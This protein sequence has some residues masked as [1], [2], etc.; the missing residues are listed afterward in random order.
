LALVKNGQQQGIFTF[1]RCVIHVPPA[2]CNIRYFTRCC[3]TLTAFILNTRGWVGGPLENTRCYD[4]LFPFKTLFFV[5]FLF[6]MFLISAS[7]E[8]YS[9]QPFLYPSDL[10]SF[11]II[12]IGALELMNKCH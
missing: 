8:G 10:L 11:C 6:C 5:L 7:C 9:L 2:E 1:S 3:I 12:T 4:V